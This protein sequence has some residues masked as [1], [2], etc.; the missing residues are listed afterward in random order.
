MENDVETIKQ[1]F[2]IAEKMY[3]DM[4]KESL[5]KLLLLRDTLD[6][7]LTT[8]ENST[9]LWYYVADETGCKYITDKMP[10]QV[11]IE[12]KSAYN[13]LFITSG[14]V[15][16]RIPRCLEHLFPEIKYGDGPIKVT[17]TIS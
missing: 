4:S 8:N 11:F 10:E 15:N 3:N 17:L 9:E 12:D 7:Q 5:V 16:I 14:E 13:G 2:T 6:L 1:D